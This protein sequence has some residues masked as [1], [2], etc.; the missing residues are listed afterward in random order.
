MGGLV[1][2]TTLIAL[3]TLLYISLYTRGLPSAT[4]SHTVDAA[5]CCPAKTPPCSCGSV[6]ILGVKHYIRRR[7]DVHSALSMLLMMHHFQRH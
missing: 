2:E 5:L 7:S 3:Y 1:H 4:G 6:D